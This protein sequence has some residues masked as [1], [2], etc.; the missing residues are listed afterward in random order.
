MDKVTMKIFKDVYK[1]LQ[2]IKIDTESKSL[3]DTILLLIKAYK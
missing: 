3:S 1:E 2:K